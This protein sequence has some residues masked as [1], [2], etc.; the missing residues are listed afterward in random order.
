MSETLAPAYTVLDCLGLDVESKGKDSV[1]ES[2]CLTV[3]LVLSFD[4][5]FY[6]IGMLIS[7]SAYLAVAFVTFSCTLSIGKFPKR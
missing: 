4:S 2:N 5:F 6:T 7:S 1:L 3:N